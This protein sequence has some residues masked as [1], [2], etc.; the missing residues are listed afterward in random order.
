MSAQEVFY[1]Q[2]LFELFED[3]DDA[4][5]AQVIASLKE[6]GHPDQVIRYVVA[7]G[8]PNFLPAD[9]AEVI[10]K[11]LEM[12]V[13]SSAKMDFSSM[14]EIAEYL[15]K[16]GYAIGTSNCIERLDRVYRFM[17]SRSSDDPAYVANTFAEKSENCLIVAH[18]AA[19]NKTVVDGVMKWMM[20]CHQDQAIWLHAFSVVF[21]SHQQLNP[22]FV[23]VGVSAATGS[24]LSIESRAELLTA[25]ARL[26]ETFQML[27]EKAEALCDLLTCESLDGDALACL[28]L[29]VKL[30]GMQKDAK[31]K[32]IMMN[33][34]LPFVGPS[35][36]AFDLIVEGFCNV[37]TKDEITM[38]CFDVMSDFAQKCIA[39]RFP[40]EYTT[41]FIFK[42]PVEM[43]VLDYF[44]KHNKFPLIYLVPL[45]ENFGIQQFKD[46]FRLRSQNPRSF[47]N[48]VV[49]YLPFC[50]DF[51]KLHCI[52]N[53]LASGDDIPLV[54]ASEMDSA[55][56]NVASQIIFNPTRYSELLPITEY[57][58]NCKGNMEAYR[59]DRPAEA[60]TPTKDFNS[61]K[62]VASRTPEKRRRNSV[63][64]PKKE[65]ADSGRN[66]SIRKRRCSVALE[67]SEMEIE[68]QSPSVTPR[69]KRPNSPRPPLKAGD[70]STRVRPHNLAMKIAEQ[71]ESV[72]AW[73][74]ELLAIITT[75]IDQYDELAAAF[76]PIL[77]TNRELLETFCPKSDHV[78]S[79]FFG[80]LLSRDILGAELL[81]SFLAAS[82]YSESAVSVALS[83][84]S[85]S[86][87]V[88]S[89]IDLYENVF[90][91]GFSY[92]RLRQLCCQAIVMTCNMSETSS[93][94]LSLVLLK[95]IEV[96]PSLNNEE[97]EAVVMHLL[98]S[99]KKIANIET[100]I[101]AV[102]TRPKLE[103]CLLARWPESRHLF[104]DKIEKMLITDPDAYE[105]LTRNR[106]YM[107][108]PKYL[109]QVCLRV[110]REFFDEIEAKI[111]EMNSEEALYA[112]TRL[113]RD[114]NEQKKKERKRFCIFAPLLIDKIKEP[115][116]IVPAYVDKFSRVT[117]WK[118]IAFI[119]PLLDIAR[120][121]FVYFYGQ[122]GV[123]PKCHFLNSIL[124]QV[125]Q[126]AEFKDQCL[127]CLEN[128]FYSNEPNLSFAFLFFS[129]FVQFQL[130]DGD[131][132]T[133]STLLV[134]IC[135][136]LLFVRS[137]SDV[138]GLHHAISAL[139]TKIGIPLGDE[140]ADFSFK[141]ASKTFVRN[142]FLLEPEIVQGFIEKLQKHKSKIVELSTIFGYLSIQLGKDS[143]NGR[144]AAGLY[145]EHC[146]K[147]MH[148]KFVSRID[149]SSL[150]D[151][152]QEKLLR[153]VLK[154]GSI[155]ALS[156]VVASCR[157]L[158]LSRS[159]SA[160]T[161]RCLQKIFCD[162]ALDIVAVLFRSD[163]MKEHLLSDKGFMERFVPVAIEKPQVEDILVSAFGPEVFDKLFLF[164]ITQFQDLSF[165]ESVIR[166]AFEVLQSAPTANHMRKF[167]CMLAP[168]LLLDVGEFAS[169]KMQFA[170]LLKTE[171]TETSRDILDRLN[172]RNTPDE[173]DDV[174]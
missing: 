82:G 165:Y 92:E 140:D 138:H 63:S 159:V 51:D 31:L 151:D 72:P 110:S 113:L 132:S 23:H 152:L 71:I 148:E 62:P 137:S 45:F 16:L 117:E 118:E 46:L 102:I 58:R 81:E 166:R 68:T 172:G 146:Q 142:F 160:V 120:R 40:T 42:K 80:N 59:L 128:E 121:D 13:L 108:S 162:A 107:P 154:D 77:A 88:Y 129:K 18:I 85:I 115:G 27:V 167:L 12:Y 139:S 158:V 90:I 19:L 3:G 168:T 17:F 125:C 52:A 24:T 75:R 100:V 5:K 119:Y 70:R 84:M 20:K 65:A 101:E 96:A 41:P 48:K 56:I 37:I 127:A 149:I 6:Y 112:L 73:S 134:L 25:V 33:K 141:T 15:S 87:K 86:Q 83:S 64:T 94:D 76:L 105:I 114:F 157:E 28:E 147:L 136:S 36:K 124:K 66:S 130:N 8:T 103:S 30:L 150:T 61:D 135:W 109:G 26:P 155:A 173:S 174:S 116:V 91:L 79:I 7:K 57:L 47:W 95:A 143:P 21:L 9:Y 50:R 53:V 122:L 35:D 2:T 104:F 170:E 49:R 22:E 54:I 11:F 164:G 131:V 93:I 144:R 97:Y 111:E 29:G 161:T 74:A 60:I 156:V 169:V 38:S 44:A 39:A 10:F 14:V 123:S 43:R 145:L 171:D 99:S 89:D 67:S 69:N 98:A 32:D 55:Y 153:M 34:V 126:L 4:K 163:R 133:T 106:M 1:L 78:K